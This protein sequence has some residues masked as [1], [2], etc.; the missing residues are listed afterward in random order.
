MIRG[1]LGRYVAQH[2]DDLLERC[3]HA[4]LDARGGEI[5]LDRRDGPSARR[6]VGGARNLPVSVSA[7]SA[8]HVNEAEKGLYGLFL[9]S[10][11]LKSASGRWQAELR[12]AESDLASRIAALSHAMDAAGAAA[13]FAQLVKHAD[14]V[15]QEMDAVES[16]LTAEPSVKGALPAALRQGLARAARL[17]ADAAHVAES[18]KLKRVP[19]ADPYR[20]AVADAERRIHTLAQGLFDSGLRTGSQ[21]RAPARHST[22]Q[23]AECS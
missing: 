10:Q 18:Q 11:Y 15:R 14:R 1:Y 23:A 17:A 22:V 20:S 8:Q 16:A 2:C 19:A 12:A 4:Y 21:V 9:A 6:G 5:W 7:C 13:A 3:A